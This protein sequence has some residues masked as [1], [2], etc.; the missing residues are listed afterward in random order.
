MANPGESRHTSTRSFRGAG[1]LSPPRR[2]RSLGPSLARGCLVFL[3]TGAL[4]GLVGAPWVNGVLAGEVPQTPPPSPPPAQRVPGPPPATPPARPA[5]FLDD[6]AAQPGQP[7]TPPGVGPGA[8]L[9]PAPEVV[10]PPPHPLGTLPAPLPPGPSV[11][12][13]PL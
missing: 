3:H 8:M 13:S 9:P 11:P 1:A 2:R 7:P 10:L 4:L 12:G 6:V 5:V